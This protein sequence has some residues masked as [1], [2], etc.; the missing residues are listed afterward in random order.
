MLFY[1]LLVT[2]VCGG[3][4]TPLLLEYLKAKEE[5]ADVVKALEKA[6]KL[7]TSTVK[8]QQ[9]PCCGLYTAGSILQHF[10][11]PVGSFLHFQL[12]E[13][14]FLPQHIN[15]YI[16]DIDSGKVDAINTD[17][18]LD[19]FTGVLRTVPNRG[20]VLTIY[21][22]FLQNWSC[23]GLLQSDLSYMVLDKDDL[24]LLDAKIPI[25]DRP[26]VSFDNCQVVGKK[27]LIT[28]AKTSVHLPIKCTRLLPCHLPHLTDHLCQICDKPHLEDHVCATNGSE[29]TQLNFK[30]AQK[31]IE[32]SNL[33]STLHKLTEELKPILSIGLHAKI[34]LF[35]FIATNVEKIKSF[36]FSFQQFIPF[37]TLPKAEERIIF[38]FGDTGSGKSTFISQKFGLSFLV[39]H[40]SD[41]S[42]SVTIVDSGY[43]DVSHIQQCRVVE[44]GGP[45]D[46]RWPTS[47][48]NYAIIQQLELQKLGKGESFLAIVIGEITPLLQQQMFS[49]GVINYHLVKDD[50]V[51]PKTLN[52]AKSI[53]EQHDN[54]Y[55]AINTCLCHLDNKCLTYHSIPPSGRNSAFLSLSRSIEILDLMAYLS[56]TQL[57]QLLNDKTIIKIHPPLTNEEHKT[58]LESVFFIKSLG[59]SGWHY[60]PETESQYIDS[61]PFLI[62]YQPI[63]ESKLKLQKPLAH[64]IIKTYGGTARI[65]YDDGNNV[66]LKIA[67]TPLDPTFKCP[68]GC[69]M[70]FVNGKL[71]IID[72]STTFKTNNA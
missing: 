58:M 27:V 37:S 21:P 33:E 72:S 24:T 67:G 68:I 10:R 2:F 3:A 71:Y 28:Q 5:Q 69:T 39:H 8:T 49:L 25:F 17:N 54:I 34:A 7:G 22:A 1:L 30:L 11:K 47:E 29:V 23:K 20:L 32:I 41:L 56:P 4:L 53:C 31:E 46:T 66:C 42:Q 6:R 55:N 64:D 57:R 12:L 16:N 14:D 59:Y 13:S 9:L 70:I 63:D 48:Q 26:L 19:L 36:G 50:I 51:L 40:G 52:G 65:V 15:S 62:S 60:I 44:I 45:N 35:E 61:P 38:V 18:A 43:S